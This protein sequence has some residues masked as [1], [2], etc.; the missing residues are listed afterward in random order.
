MVSMA[1]GYLAT[2]LFAQEV[3]NCCCAMGWTMGQSDIAGAMNRELRHYKTRAFGAR[4]FAEFPLHPSN[5]EIWQDVAWDDLA[6]LKEQMAKTK[7]RAARMIA[8]PRARS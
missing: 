1:V 4:L 3:G 5:S 8:E 7:A 2:F 6:K